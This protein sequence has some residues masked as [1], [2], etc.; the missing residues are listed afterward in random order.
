MLCF[1]SLLSC[2]VEDVERSDKPVEKQNLDEST[3]EI[4]RVK[5]MNNQVLSLVHQD[6]EYI[7]DGDIIITADQLN[8]LKTENTSK[9][10]VVSDL[11]KR[12][13]GGNVH[14]II[15][16]NFQNPQKVYNAI[17]MWE[18][19]VPGLN[20]IEGTSTNYI[21]FQNSTVN[22]SYLGRQGGEQIINIVSY[23]DGVVAHEIGHALG[24]FHEQSRSD[25]DNFIAIQWSNIESGKDHNFETYIDRGLGGT[26]VGA[27]DFNSIMLYDS[28]AFSNGNGPT[29]TK[30]NGSTFYTNRSYLSTGDISAGNYMYPLPGISAMI[31]GPVK[32]N[33]YS[34][35]TWSVSVQ[36]G[37]PPYTY[38]WKRINPN[39]IEYSWG[40]GTSSYTTNMPNGQDLELEVKVTDS[41]GNIANA[42]H[43]TMNTGSGSGGIKP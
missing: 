33:N 23:T 16:S 10:A 11:S 6:G 12:W 24:M 1:I 18:S 25:R 20:F 30:L 3:Q 8:L 5:L 4:I 38:E 39:G 34:N 41:D 35:Y 36:N 2:Q 15:S 43:Y 13:A 7:M 14:F 27:F 22:N 26:D 17:S 31:S 28:Y 21:K 40:D 32:A 37:V 19:E 9:G 42:G 29:I